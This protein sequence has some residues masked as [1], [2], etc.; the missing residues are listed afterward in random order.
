[1][2][3]YFLFSFVS[4]AFNLLTKSTKGHHSSLRWVYSFTFT[5]KL[6]LLHGHSIIF[7]AKQK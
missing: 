5:E 1:M 2:R 6:K 4:F 3:V 7:M